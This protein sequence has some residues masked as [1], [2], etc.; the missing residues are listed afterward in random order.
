MSNGENS[1]GSMRDWT[2][3]VNPASSGG[4]TKSAWPSIFEQLCAIAAQMGYEHPTE[5][6]V[7]ESMGM[8]SATDLTRKVLREGAKVVVAVGGDGTLSEVME[9][10]FEPD[11][12]EMINDEAVIGY[13]QSGTGSDFRRTLGWQNQDLQ[14]WIVRLLRRQTKKLDI[15]G[16][17]FTGTDGLMKKRHFINMSSCGVSASIAKLANEK[18]KMFGPN[19]TY[20]MVTPAILRGMI[21]V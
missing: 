4:K 15:C 6:R 1:F 3:I 17:C 13:L 11:T 9:G 21:F 16:S 19:L 20:I 12:D 2:I 8:G 5:A 18:Y 10:F 14:E 7:L